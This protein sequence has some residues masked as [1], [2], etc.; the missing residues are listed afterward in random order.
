MISRLMPVMVGMLAAAVPT[1]VAADT[2]V[3][4]LDAAGRLVAPMEPV[5]RKLDKRRRPNIMQSF[6]RAAV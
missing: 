3:V 1:V 6:L 4:R 2:K 5:K